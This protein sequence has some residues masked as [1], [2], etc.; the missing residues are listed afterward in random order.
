MKR[1]L[2]LIVLMCVAANGAQRKKEQTYIIEYCDPV[3]TKCQLVRVEGT[4]TLDAILNAF[5]PVTVWTAAD[6]NK[7]LPKGDAPAN[8]IP[9]TANR[10]S[11]AR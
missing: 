2:A 5:W 1:R 7:N 9:M 6:Y 10:H 3:T 4:D 8:Q 11:V